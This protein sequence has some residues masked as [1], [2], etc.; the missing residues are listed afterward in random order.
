MKSFNIALFL[1][2]IAMVSNSQTMVETIFDFGDF[3]V[4]TD[5]IKLEDEGFIILGETTTDSVHKSFFIRLNDNG[6]T[7]WTKLIS[8]IETLSIKNVKESNDGGLLLCGGIKINDKSKPF[9]AK[10]NVCGEKEWCTVFLTYNGSVH[11]KD[12]V[13][14]SN[15]DI[16]VIVNQYDEIDGLY[17]FNLNSSGEVLWKKPV[18]SREKYPDSRLPLGWSIKLSSSGDFLIAGDVYWKN[19]WDD[20]FPTR[21]LFAM[22][23][24]EGNE[25]W[26]LP[27]GIN[28]TIHSHSLNIVEQPNGNF[29]G[30]GAY[31]SPSKKTSNS[32]YLSGES[33]FK[34][35]FDFE[36]RNGLLMA[37]DPNGNELNHFIAD[38]TEIDPAYKYQVFTDL[39]FVDSVAIIGGIFDDNPQFPNT[40]EIVIDTSFFDDTFNVYHRVKH[41]N[42]Y[43]TISYGLTS[44]NKVLCASTDWHTFD[45]YKMYLTKLNRNLEQ[46]SIYTAT[47]EYDYLCDHEIESGIIYL[48]DCNIVVSTDDAIDIEQNSGI[49][50]IISPNPAQNKSVIKFK[51]VTDQTDLQIRV[52]NIFGKSI[53]KAAL[54]NGQIE[55]HLDVHSWEKGVYTIQLKSQQKSIATN[56]LIKM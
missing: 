30:L 35:K 8:R 42:A 10:L 27:F 2:L 17:L 13:E 32:Y 15:G 43:E 46:D 3:D 54:F 52:I 25:K 1:L 38:F 29:L 55:L 9:A 47:Y 22:I 34:K 6:D 33:T 41:D 39:F 23:D 21:S 31:W 4:V 44:D 14:T 5:I 7:L 50:I 36:F 37:I 26:L 18:C 19:P 24:N 49:S 12:I 16:G 51:G 53:Y 28:D 20:L 56:K 11:A 45:D 40:G 48:D